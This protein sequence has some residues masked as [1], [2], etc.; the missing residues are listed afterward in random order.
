MGA[1]DLVWMSLLAS[2]GL[3]SEPAVEAAD[4]AQLALSVGAEKEVCDQECAPAP[5]DL[6]KS[7]VVVDDEILKRFPLR[8]VLDQLTTSAGTSNSADDIWKQWWSSQRV[9]VGGDPAHHPFCDDN[10]GTINGFPITCPREEE[11]LANERLETHA[12]VAL[13]N[14]FDLAPMDGAHCG[15][16]RIVYAMGGDDEAAKLQS[17]SSSPEV[18]SGRNFVIFEGVLPNP[19]PECGLAACLPVAQFWQ[20]LSSEPSVTVRADRL[21]EFYF[22]GICDFEPVVLPEHYGLDCRDG[23]GYGGACGQIRT[24]QFVEKEWNLREF[25]LRRDSG[26][27][28][29]QQTTVAQNPHFS[30]FSSFAPLFPSFEPD[31]LAQLDRQVPVPDGVNVIGAATSPRFDAGES[32]AQGGPLANDYLPDAAFHASIGSELGALGIPGT[33][34][35]T[36]AAE[37]ATAQSCG[38]CHELSNSD[39]LGNTAGFGPNVIWPDSLRFVHVDEASNLSP[40]LLTEFLPHRQT[41]MDNYL[42][43]TCGESCLGKDLFIVK[44]IE[45]DARTGLP[46]VR[47]ELLEEE[48]FRR[49]EQTLPPFDT[50]SGRLVH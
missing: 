10:G 50:I 6:F 48:E 49:I 36:D 25:T 9:R 43:T 17:G 29:V 8:R 26:E 13:F 15:E 12:P 20:G 31:Y 46:L 3:P 1:R 24:N 44:V 32:V 14:R 2:C 45:S 22:K 21:E 19:H 28:I 33:A 7:F 23:S 40:A 5:T 35:S 4:P 42:A 16:Y 11:L 27:L 47:F 41:V 34:S 37:R 39:D 38:G 18:R 30:L